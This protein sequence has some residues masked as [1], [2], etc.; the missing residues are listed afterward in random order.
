MRTLP[1]FSGRRH[2]GPVPGGGDVAAVS[3]AAKQERRHYATL[4]HR[5]PPEWKPT[6]DPGSLSGVRKGPT[7]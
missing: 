7:P 5:T 3:A 2:G 4:R 6:T 1:L